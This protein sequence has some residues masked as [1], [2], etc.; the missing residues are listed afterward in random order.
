MGSQERASLSL[1]IPEI[2]G[3]GIVLRMLHDTGT[4]GIEFYVSANGEKV[5]IRI[6]QCRFIAALPESSGPSMGI[7]KVP[8][9]PP[10]Q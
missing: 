4:N 1:R 3:P 8:Y 7:V 2:A 6:H 9:I 5:A 10:P